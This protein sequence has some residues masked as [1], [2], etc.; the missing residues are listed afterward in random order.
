MEVADIFVLNKADLP[1][2]DRAEAQ[3]HAWVTRADDAGWSPPIVRTVAAEGNGVDELRAAIAAHEEWYA[4]SDQAGE[5]RR[6]LAAMRLRTLLR[7]RL[8]VELRN[9]GFNAEAEGKV[10]D[11]I[12]RGDV[13]PH[14]AAQQIVD[15]V[16]GR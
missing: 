4:S 14:S 10:V 2:T 11:A 1:G 12:A 7:E 5:K 6:S 13:D 9:N 16:F 3:L 15:E 8:L